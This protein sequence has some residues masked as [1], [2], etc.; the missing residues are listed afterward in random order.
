[1]TSSQTPPLTPEQR[2]DVDQIRRDFPVLSRQVH[3]HPLVYL[4]NAATAQK[5]RAVLDVLTR[6]YEDNNANIHRGVHALSQTATE[7]Y[8]GSRSKIGRFIGAHEDREIVFVRGT[9]EAINLVA[10]SFV[11]PRLQPG[12]EVLITAMEHH[13]NIVPWQILCNEKSARL[14]VV[15]INEAGE[16]DL[17]E[18][19]DLLTSRTKIVAL[20]HMSNALGTINPVPDI[21]AA[22]HSQGVPVLLDG[23]QAAPH[24]NV[25]VADLD[26]DFY[27]F[28]G[29][30]LYGPT[31]IGVLYGKANHLESMD[32]YQTGGE[33][34]KSVTFEKT[35]YND[36]PYRFEAGTPHIAGVIALGAAIDYVDSLGRDRI[37][38]HENEILAYGTKLLSSIPGL[39]LIGTATNKASVLSFL[40]G[41]IHP[42]DIGTIL[43]DKG[44]AIRT[45]H[46]CAQP[47]MDRFGISATARASLAFY[48][49]K[50]D[51]D[52][53]VQGLE[54][55]RD[56][57]G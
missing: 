39:R 57:L 33:Q 49:T 24:M 16:L 34:I 14:R 40:L 54:Q 13:S 55:V 53:L 17:D 11:R 10:H 26:C 29:H 4:D 45:G 3:G 47:V 15:P 18:F 8:E 19:R 22:S 30:K 25:N 21:I 37:A 6:Y 44:I 32:P 43:D 52:A 1:V 42:H 23:A 2:L 31:G 56:V 5:P 20:A 38:A 9:T 12:D 48:N 27:A 36:I 35:I 51:I 50:Y 28:S 7:Q 46:H 41:D